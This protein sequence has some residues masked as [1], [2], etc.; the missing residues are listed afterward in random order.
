MLPGTC[1]TMNATSRWTS[2]ITVTGVWRDRSLTPAQRVRAG[3]DAIRRGAGD[4]TFLL[5]CGAPQGACIGVVDGMRIG[6]DVAPACRRS[7]RVPMRG[8]AESLN[9]SVTAAL[10]LYAATRG[11]PGDLPERQRARLLL[12]GLALTLPH[13]SEMLE[14]KGF[15]IP[16]PSELLV[17]P[18]PPEPAFGR[19]ARKHYALAPA[20]RRTSDE[21]P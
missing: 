11:R 10:L 7:V 18:Y 8:F 5:G 4:D 2:R 1:A 17:G 13:A 3:Y 19:Y 9:V 15:A 6:P 14:A 16:A 20:L 21:L 12:R